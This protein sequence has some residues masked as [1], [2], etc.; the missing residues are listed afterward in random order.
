MCGCQT[1][2]HSS[3]ITTRFTNA[4]IIFF[5]PSYS[6]INMQSIRGQA[7]FRRTSYSPVHRR[8]RSQILTSAVSRPNDA[9]SESRLSASVPGALAA[10]TATF[11]LSASSASADVGAINPFEGVQ[12]NSLYVTGGLVLMCIPGDFSLMLTSPDAAWLLR[13]PSI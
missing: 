9:A 7:V 6:D 1:V 5:L 11:L 2:R 8:F 10:A 3:D 13:P 4:C 12:A